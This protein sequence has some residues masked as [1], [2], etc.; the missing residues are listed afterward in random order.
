E[1][2]IPTDNGLRLFATRRVTVS[3]ESGAPQYLIKTSDD[4][5]DRRETESRMAH[6]A[7]HDGLTGMPN[8]AA[9]LQ[10]LEQLIDACGDTDEEFAVLSVDLRRF[11]E[12]NDVLGHETG[13]KLLIEVAQRLEKAAGSGVV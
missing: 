7:Y 5:T 1:H 2:P 10:S 9:F 8:R 4:I 12:I 13:D 3:D 6:M 11:R